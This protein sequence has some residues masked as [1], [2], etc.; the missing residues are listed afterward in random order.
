VE[1]GGGLRLSDSSV[2]KVTAAPFAVPEPEVPQA[3][4][5]GEQAFGQQ[6]G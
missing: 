5:R 1:T 3:Q 6:A 4:S 2:L